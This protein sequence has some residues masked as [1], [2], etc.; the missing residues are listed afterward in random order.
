MKLV[1]TAAA[2]RIGAS[3][4]SHTNMGN[5]YSAS[6]G[7]NP[8]PPSHTRSPVATSDSYASAKRLQ[9]SIP[10]QAI[11][12][13]AMDQLPAPALYKLIPAARKKAEFKAT[14]V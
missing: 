10:A 6:S 5:R 4:C 8:H 14:S 12:P 1:T 13:A 3:Q 11:T 7:W 9:A 2:A